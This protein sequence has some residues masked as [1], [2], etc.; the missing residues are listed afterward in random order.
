L[1]D[2]LLSFSHG[3]RLLGLYLQV[4]E[5]LLLPLSLLDNEET[6]LDLLVPELVDVL[7]LV[8]LDILQV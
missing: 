1:T 6:L 5:F 2:I 8:I 4:G 3:L 7:L